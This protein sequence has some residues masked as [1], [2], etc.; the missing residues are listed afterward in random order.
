MIFAPS[1]NAEATGRVLNEHL[2]P[3]LRMTMLSVN[4]NSVPS[5][6]G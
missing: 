2:E 5:F 3:P 1:I 4:D 6:E